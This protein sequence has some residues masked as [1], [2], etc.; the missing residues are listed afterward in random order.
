MSR[1]NNPNIPESP[2][3]ATDAT[4]DRRRARREAVLVAAA[5]AAA[6]AAG[7]A[8]LWLASSSAIR[9]DYQQYLVGLALAAASQID[10]EMHATIRDPA[11][12]NGPDYLQAVAPLRRFAAAIGDV[13]YVYTV[14]RDGE[15]IR[16]VLDAASPGDA[17]GDGVQD[18]S[19]VWQPY[20]HADPAMIAVLDGG[21]PIATDQ[22]VLRRVG[23]IHDGLRSDHRRERRPGRC[24]RSR[25]RRAPV[26]RAPREHAQLGAH[27]LA[28]AALVITVI[29]L[30]F[31]RIRRR[32]LAAAR[33]AASAAA[34]AR[35]AAEVL[36]TEKERLRHSERKFRS[37][38]EL[39][40]VGIALNDLETGR[41]L[42][43][44]DAMRRADGLHARGAARA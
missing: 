7:I 12:L 43:V 36:A 24:R 32:G 34:D 31:Y 15:T 1:L 16:F 26:S 27:R 8:G 5:T 39:S 6:T 18:Q 28:P 22:P 42:Q 41:F 14:L 20:G 3:A 25:R 29:G 23:R 17:D 38:F 11:A 21:E 9:S 35:R 4:D 10:S 30:A 37:L 19:G 13:K 44:N 2:S 40:P 33:K